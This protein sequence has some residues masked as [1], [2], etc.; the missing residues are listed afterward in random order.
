HQQQPPRLLSHSRGTVSLFMTK[1]LPAVAA[2]LGERNWQLAADTG[3]AVVSMQPPRQAA[4]AG[5]SL[6]MNRETVPLDCENNPGGLPL[7][8]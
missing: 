2:C 6:V 4:T 3:A 1:L 8:C 5:S 7:M